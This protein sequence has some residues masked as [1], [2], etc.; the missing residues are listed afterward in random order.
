MQFLFVCDTP[1]RPPEVVRA[2][3]PFIHLWDLCFW[4][5]A[6]LGWRGSFVLLQLAASR[7]VQCVCVCTCMHVRMTSLATI[8][9]VR[10]PPLHTHMPAL[11]SLLPRSHEQGPQSNLTCSDPSSHE[12]CQ[13]P[14]PWHVTSPPTSL[15]GDY[16]D[17][18]LQD[19]SGL[20]SDC[21]VGEINSLW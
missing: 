17:D 2:G 5:R 19:G 15:C 11:V 20:F 16:A 4:Q 7:E 3:L 6:V 1:H 9:T 18:S 21:S 13:E 8:T 12:A 10:R 14:T